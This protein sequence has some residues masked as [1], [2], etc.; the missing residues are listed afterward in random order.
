MDQRFAE[1]RAIH[2]KT[3]TLEEV[4]QKWE[5]R[6]GKPITLGQVREYYR[7]VKPRFERGDD[8]HELAKSH[9]W[10]DIIWRL[11]PGTE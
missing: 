2:N 10:S 11:R 6:K 4:R 9:G 5:D 3:E 8:L 1:L 7:L